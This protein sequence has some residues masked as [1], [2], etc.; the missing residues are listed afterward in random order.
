MLN[1]DELL[2][3]KLTELEN[4]QPLDAVL[5][6]LPE[7]AQELGALLRLAAAVRT[8][9]HPEPVAETIAAQRQQVRAAAKINTQP[10]PRPAP[11][12]TAPTIHAQP[13]RPAPSHSGFTWRW[14]GAGALALAG[15]TALLVFGLVLAGISF[16]MSSRT[17]DS[18]RIEN[19]TGQVQVASARGKWENVSVGYHFREGDRIRTLGASNATLTFFEGTHT[20]LS[21][22][23][24][25]VFRELNGASGGVLQVRIDQTAGETWNKVTPFQGKHNSYFLV[26]TPSGLASVHG[27]SFNV[28]VAKTGRAR[29]SVDTGEVRVQKD[30]QEVTLLAGQTTSASPEGEIEAPTYQFNISGSVTGIDEINGV[31]TISGVDFQTSDATVISGEPQLGDLVSVTGRILDGSSRIAD[32]IEALSGDDMTAFFTGPIDSMEGEDWL[33]GGMPVKVNPETQLGSDLEPGTPVKVTFNILEDGSWLA[34]RIESL[35]KDPGLPDPTPT[36]TADPR[37]MPSYEFA[38]DEL[39]TSACGQSDFQLTGTLRNTSD[40]TKDYA[41]NVQLGY[42]IDRGGE[43]ISTVQLSPSGWTRI[44]AGQAVNFNIRVTMNEKWPAAES[45]EENQVKLR[46]FV[47]SATNRPDHLIGRLTVTIEAGCRLTP[48]PSGTPG[49]PTLTPVTTGTPTLLPTAFTATA[50]AS[51]TPLATQGSG[52]CTGANPHPTGMKLA[53]RYGVPYEEIMYWFC[54]HY[55]FGEIDMAYS[56]ARQ[57]GIPVEQVFSMRASGMGWGEIKKQLAP[58]HGKDKENKPDKGK[59][60]KD[61]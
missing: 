20:F 5:Q 51:A 44:E 55:G 42:L 40:E 56:L 43:Y 10:V 54:Q 16:W 36:A 9:P 31:W 30:S 38:P 3:Q 12:S 25:L 32:S 2:D 18:A 47:A 22:N 6:S 14:L 61:K 58:D 26:E 15:T 4:G 48:T 11:S 49:T 46:I 27:T 21:P 8:A 41:A 29:F 24:E 52:Q 19:L 23:S 35:V 28:R 53:Q 59:D 34:L 60:K 50:V 57:A 1:H 17:M 39:E 45:D 37:A 33:V 7:E 13:S